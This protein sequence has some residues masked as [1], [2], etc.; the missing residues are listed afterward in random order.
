MGDKI[1]IPELEL[2]G[3]LDT[4]NEAIRRKKSLQLTYISE[5]LLPSPYA[6]QRSDSKYD[7][8][9][10]LNSVVCTHAN[11]I[12]FTTN[13]TEMSIVNGKTMIS[14]STPPCLQWSTL[15]L[16]SVLFMYEQMER[17]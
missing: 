16:S 6:A 11:T 17:K 7:Q 5:R 10:K 3:K 13:V 2:I 12:M 4:L 15:R 14:S 9:L 8:T 1:A